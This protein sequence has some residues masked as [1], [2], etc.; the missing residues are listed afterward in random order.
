MIKIKNTNELFELEPMKYW[1]LP[2]G[3]TDI[4][5]QEKLNLALSTGD[6]V[7]SLKTDGNLIRAIVTPERFALQTRGRGR[8]TG[9]FGEIQDKVFW[10]DAIANAFEDTTVLIGEAYIEGQVDRAVG[11]VLRC[12]TDKALAR[13]KGENVVKFRIFDCFYYN[14]ESLLNTPLIERIKYLPKAV[15][16]IGHELVSYVKYYEA[17]PETFWDKL[18]TIFAAG[19]EGVVLYKRNMTPCENRT[20]AW[21]TIK[22]KQVLKEYIDCFIYGIEPAEKNYTGKEIESWQYWMDDKTGEKFLGSYY[23]QY[24]DGGML[25]PIS[26]GYYYNWPGAIKCAVYDENHIPVVLCKCSGLTEEFKA[27]LRDNY[28]EWHMCPVKIDGMMLSKDSKTGSLSVRHPKLVSIRDNDIDINDC[29]LSK[30]V[31]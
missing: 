19:G 6:Y 8:N 2:S 13:Q 20:P 31:K 25:I 27:K 22:V 18:S 5:R 28:D 30:V 21:Q 17:K 15:E 7:Y 24:C 14:G 10:A 9:V 3:L 29:L 26:K 12:L 1:S 4:E 11:S 23:L 16:A